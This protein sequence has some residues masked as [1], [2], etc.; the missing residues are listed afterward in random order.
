MSMT[1]GYLSG[2][3]SLEIGGRAISLGRVQVP[4]EGYVDGSQIRLIASL[5]SV[6]EVVQEVLNTT[7]TEEA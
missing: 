4:V 3:L 1:F 7:T 5:A 6:R 2:E